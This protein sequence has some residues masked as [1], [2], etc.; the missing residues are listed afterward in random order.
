[1]AGRVYVGVSGR[2]RG[3]TGVLLDVVRECGA[4]AGA[5]VRPS[6]A[7]AVGADDAAT[8]V[9]RPAVSR[10][11]AGPTG[12][13]AEAG[14]AGDGTVRAGLGTA[15]EVDPS[16]GSTVRPRAGVGASPEGVRRCGTGALR[17]AAGV[18]VAGGRDPGAAGLTA[19]AGSG[20]VAGAADAGFV[21]VA[22][23]T[24]AAGGAGTA[25]GRTGTS[26]TPGVA[27]AR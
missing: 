19:S 1:M 10:W 3:C 7:G 4:E 20:G 13:A 8:G 23:W 11:M 26:V 9:G 25:R 16:G 18:G 5:V 21:P 17:A 15:T 6:A 24:G 12:V 14:A 2:V 22:R 27:A